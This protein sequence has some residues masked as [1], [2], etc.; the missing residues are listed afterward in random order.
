MFQLAGS[1]AG[2]ALTRFSLL[3]PLRICVTQGKRWGERERERERERGRASE[4]EEG[5]QT[6]YSV[7]QSHAH[8]REAGIE[9]REAGYQ[10]SC[11]HRL[12]L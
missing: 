8:P 5:W 3:I 2:I 11:T 4:Q 7:A 12:K 10:L 6:G 1:I 9:T